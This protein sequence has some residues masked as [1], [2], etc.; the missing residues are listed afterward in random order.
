MPDGVPGFFVIVKRSISLNLHVS[1]SKTFENPEIHGNGWMSPD[2]TY[3]DDITIN[4]V[5]YNVEPV[6]IVPNRY[7]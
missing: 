2:P 1:I 4:G 3:V 5:T 7:G 6:G